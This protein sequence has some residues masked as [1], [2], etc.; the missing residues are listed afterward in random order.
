[1]KNKLINKTAGMSYLEISI[2]IV[3]MFAVSYLI[4]SAV[5]NEIKPVDTQ[6]GLEDISQE[7]LN[8]DTG[9]NIPRTLIVGLIDYIITQALSDNIKLVDAADNIG[10][11]CCEKTKDGKFCQNALPGECDTGTGLHTSPTEC[12]LTDFCEFGCCVSPTNGICNKNTPKNQCVSLNGTYKPSSMCN[13]EDC[14]LGCCVIGEQTEFVTRG[15]CIFKT[16]AQNKD[17]PLDWRPDVNTETKCLYI[18][19]KEKEGACVYDSGSERKCIFTTLDDCISRTGNERN[20]DKTGKYCS[21]PDL[22]TTC[23]AKD[24]QGC[25]EGK[26]D[27]YWFDSCGNHEDASQDC[28]LFSGTYC[29]KDISGSYTCKDVSCMVD[30]KKRQN[31]ESWCEYDGKIGDGKDLVGSRHVKHICYM[32][33]ERIEPCDDYRNQICVESDNT[34]K[35]GE[36]FAQA[37]CRVNN[38][39]LCMSYNSKQVDA[40]KAECK[41]NPDCTLKHIEMGAGFKF[42]VCTP[43]YPPGFYLGGDSVQMNGADVPNSGE[44]ICSMATQRCTETWVCTIFGCYC[45]EN[46]DCHTAKFTNDMNDLCISLGDCGAYINYV[47]TFTDSGYGVKSTGAAPPRSINAGMFSKYVGPKANSKPADPGTFEFFETMNA[48]GLKDI[49]EEKLNKVD[50]NQSALQKELGGTLGAYGSPLL[51]RILSEDSGNVS[52]EDI[53]ALPSSTQPVNAAGYFNGVSSVKSSISAQITKKEKKVGGFEMIGAMIAGMIAYLITQSILITM[54]AAMLAYLFLMAWIMYVDI[55]FFC[56]MWERP[57]GGAD[58]YKCNNDPTQ[59][60]CSEYR[61]QSLGELCQFVNKGTPNELCI[62]QPADEAFPTIQPLETA[63]S[64]GYKYAEVTANGFEVLTE[65]DKCIDPFN[66]VKIGIKVSPFAKCRWGFDM[67]Q[68]FQEMPERFGNKGDSI[69]PAHQMNLVLPS[70]DS[71]VGVYSQGAICNKSGVFKP[72]NI[73]EELKELGKVSLYVKCKTASG[74]VNTEAYNI[75]TCVNQGPDLTPP[76]IWLTDPPNEGFLKYNIDTQNATIF[77]SEPSQCKW[78]KE[79]KDFDKMENNMTCDTDIF[80]YGTNE[81]GLGLPCTT[82]LTGLKNSTKFYIRC[83]DQSAG[84]NNMTESFI[85]ELFPSETP[86]S[87]DEMKVFGK[88]ESD[89]GP[90]KEI[91]SGVEPADIVFRLSTSG[92][93]EDGKAVCQWNLSPTSWD[94]FRETNSSTHS[95]EWTNAY[96]G[97]YNIDFQCED[98]AGN[99]AKNSSSFKVIVDKKGPEIIRIYNEGGLKV[100]TAEPSKCVYSFNRVFNFENGTEMS[101]SDTEHFAD[102]KPF[103][104]YIQCQDQFQNFGSKI[105]VRPYDIINSY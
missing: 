45:V 31:G 64:P 63:I 37:S 74:R 34:V 22:N 80:H 14:R 102:W 17:I 81:P 42:D 60:P 105:M 2:L 89:E 57:S 77:V 104:Y 98:V 87:I 36:T 75:R 29:G 88:D 10:L 69:L 13:V 21:N 58:C 78:S 1:M 55:D 41:K 90:G 39:R 62:S 11:V 84:K 93:A 16:N 5:N 15:N 99:I 40:M 35:N 20:F 4:Y 50:E 92:G 43:A 86:L 52:E 32:G 83:Q 24:H 79:D 71:I 68:T 33:T 65:N 76:R 85:Y 47:G 18:T 12:E 46:C 66:I 9:I 103:T 56:N 3:S 19:D 48:E 96:A 91:V 28:N 72:C 44:G 101:G 94:Q 49:S 70:V 97:R 73:T 7:K 8:Q 95:Y 100:T 38:W 51:Y 23:K 82:T 30:G 53:N 54:I 59:L 27:V 6:K 67:K 26:E 25:L 61:C